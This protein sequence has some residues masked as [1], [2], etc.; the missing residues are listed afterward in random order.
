MNISTYES[1]INALEAG[2]GGGG[3]SSDE[4]FVITIDYQKMTSDKTFSEVRNAV[5]NNAVILINIVGGSFIIPDGVQS[6]GDDNDIYIFIKDI[7]VNKR[8]KLEG[9]ISVGTFILHPNNELEMVQ[10]KHYTFA[11]TEVE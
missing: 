6:G 9:S 1:K 11:V 10:S 5:L 7:K 8:P 4:L 3:G 2:G